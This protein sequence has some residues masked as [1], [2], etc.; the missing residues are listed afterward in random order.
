MKAAR[1]F[2][3]KG[4]RFVIDALR[5]FGQPLVIEEGVPTLFRSNPFEAERTLA[6]AAECYIVESFSQRQR[7][8]Q[9]VLLHHAGSM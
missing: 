3:I 9:W 6:R 1:W 7:A 4:R 8:G 5:G 2:P